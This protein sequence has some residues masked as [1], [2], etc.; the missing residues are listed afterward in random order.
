MNRWTDEILAIVERM[1]SDGRSCAQ[2][3]NALGEAGFYASRNAVIG[4]IHRK[5]WK[6]AKVKPAPEKVEAPKAKRVRAKKPK[7]LAAAALPDPEPD[8]P[9]PI[10]LPP[11]PPPPPEGGVALMDLK[12][13]HCRMVVAQG[14]ALFCGKPQAFETSWCEDCAK[15]VYPAEVF[16]RLKRGWKPPQRVRAAA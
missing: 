7:A 5:G 11:P 3:A 6:R 14:P 10:D 2:I 1:W 16:D 8:A 4:V 9:E 12:S 15:I 13:W